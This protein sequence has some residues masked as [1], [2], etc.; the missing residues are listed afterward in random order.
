M[1]AAAAAGGQQ[2]PCSAGKGTQTA[3]AV[4][5]HV[6]LFLGLHLAHIR[7]MRQALGQVPDRMCCGWNACT[8]HNK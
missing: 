2:L 6:L 1:T 7:Q 5:V 4:R 8:G 3:G